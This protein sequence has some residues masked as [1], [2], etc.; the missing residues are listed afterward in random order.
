MKKILLLFVLALGACT[1]LSAQD[2]NKPAEQNQISALNQKKAQYL[3][4]VRESGGE[5]D[6][7]T[8]DVWDHPND[9]SYEYHK[10]KTKIRGDL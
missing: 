10:A 3:K 9:F 7:K 1:S 5:T 4:I 2:R 8:M 6:L